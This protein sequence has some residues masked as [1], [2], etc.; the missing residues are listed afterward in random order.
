MTTKT[1]T[2][3]HFR[4]PEGERAYK[5]S[6]AAAMKSLPEPTRT[7]DI[8]TSYGTIR[9]YE[10][11]NNQNANS[12]PIVLLPGRS[13]G[14]PMWAKNLAGLARQRTVYALDALGDAGLDVQTKALK[15]S[16]DQ[17]AWLEETFAQ[18]GL[19][20]I[21]LV[22]HSFGGWLAAN[23]AVRFPR[24]IVT[25]SLLEPVFV[26]QGL[27]WQFYIKSIPASLPFLPKSWRDKM[28]KSISGSAELDLSDPIARMIAD[29]T[30]HY[31]IKVPTPSR[32]SVA[33]LEGLS[34]P[35][36]GAMAA[37][38]PLHNPDAAVALAQ[39]HVKNVT[40][41]SWP[42]ATHSLPMEFPEQVDN[43]L[44]KFMSANETSQRSG[45]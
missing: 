38:S 15:N 35:V 24:R 40:I 36:Y 42:N 39:K 9:V 11:T 12:T 18:I 4:S 37:N 21:H 28:L 22:G 34:M 14:V 1:Q 25:L 43:E 17:A 16:A 7:L 30:E 10:F 33:Q 20:K 31:A 29:A 2:M 5:K 6:Y 27:H 19:T 41:R 23:Y 13:S 45:E 44:L 32:I 26:F 3:G 8:T